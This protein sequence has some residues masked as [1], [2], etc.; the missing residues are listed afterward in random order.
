M[1]SRW[2]EE[3]D[4]ILVL[5]KHSILYFEFGFEEEKLS[6]KIDEIIS[7]KALEFVE[8]SLGAEEK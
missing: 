2:E 6:T 5:R 4:D 8:E 1:I 3:L 7:Q